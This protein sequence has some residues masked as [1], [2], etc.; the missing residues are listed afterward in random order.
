MSGIRGVE[1]LLVGA[2]FVGVVAA[3]LVYTQYFAPRRLKR[4]VTDALLAAGWTPLDP[5]LDEAAA[6]VERLAVEGPFGAEWEATY[7][8][9]LGPVTSRV[10]VSKSTRG[11]SGGVFAD[12]S[13]PHRRY[14][15]IASMRRTTRT[16][17]N[18]DLATQTR[19]AVSHSLW[20][21]EARR[22]PVEK[23]ETVVS[24]LGER[25]GA[26]ARGF[27]EGRGVTPASW[28]EIAAPPS[29]PLAARLRQVMDA[30][31]AAR[32]FA[33][34]LYL[35]PQA[36]VLVVPLARIGSKESAILETARDISA[37]LD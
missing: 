29:H 12:P 1:G 6:R 26:A 27:A 28:P 9:R 24:A 4:R 37:A 11:I 13:S 30:H 8:E 15:A 5:G 16:K 32:S 25:F 3:V 23:A 7:A 17:S 21:G 18:L 19:M 36:W 20:I 34:S 10:R 31:G 33:G 2:V 22:L 35:S 14:A